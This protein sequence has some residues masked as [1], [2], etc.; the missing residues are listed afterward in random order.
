MNLQ[1]VLD[2]AVANNQMLFA[3]GLTGHGKCVQPRP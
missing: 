1:Q 3:V 2:A